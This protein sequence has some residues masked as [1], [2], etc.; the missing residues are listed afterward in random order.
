MKILHINTYDHGGAA[1]AAIRLHQA[2]ISQGI[3]S[4]ILFLNRTNHS[5]TASFQF[6]TINSNTVNTF[7]KRQAKRVK[8]KI[9]TPKLSNAILNQKKLQNKPTC[10]EIFSFSNTDF[11]ITNQE[12]YQ[13]ADI[14]HLHWVA[15]F[16]DYN[17]FK[18]NNKPVIWTLHDMNP[19]TGGC[20][21]SSGCEKYK[22][23]C[24]N[25]PQLQGTIN[26]NNAFIDQD[27]KKLC[28]LGCDPI[29]TAPSNWLKERSSESNLFGRYINHC[30]P[31]SLDLSVFKIY[32]KTFCKS[33]FNLP[34]NKKIILFVSETIDNKR[35]GFDI[36]LDALSLITSNNFHICVIGATNNILLDKNDITFLGKIIDERL[37]ALAYSAAD[38]F[39]LPSREDNLPNTM[40]ETLSC[41]TPVISFQVGGMPEIIKTGFNGI[42]AESVCPLSLSNAISD[43]LK[44]KY[45]FN[46]EQIRNFA[47]EKF[48]PEKQVNSYLNIYRSM[49]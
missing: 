39:V 13:E 21:Y 22:T 12:C 35:K 40:L 46:Q 25:C 28:L 43:F 3:E 2:L 1:I 7:L 38:V 18:K 31:N 33:F 10:Y 23:E 27:Y 17:F 36:L 48:S 9:F 14:I 5:A 19:F 41:G 11:D 44:D 15:G 37:L 34:L 45:I 20:H 32:D 49:V 8:N 6:E 47:V 26:P 29:I 16:V 42:L 4:A 30:I 24:N